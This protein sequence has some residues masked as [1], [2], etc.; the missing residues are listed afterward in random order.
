MRILGIDYGAKRI[1]LAL[2]DERES[3][4]FPLTILS[5]SKSVFKKIKEVCEKNNVSKI[6]LGIP[7][8][9]KAKSDLTEKAVQ[10]FKLQLQKEISLELIFENE[11]LT[12]QQAERFQ[13]KNKKIDS[14][15]AAIILQTYL[16][17]LKSGH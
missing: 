9:Y 8:G 14:S 10:N 2:S 13:G 5:N 15:A 1:G 4:A 7:L 12:T 6:V 17:R 11:V 3:L 16:D